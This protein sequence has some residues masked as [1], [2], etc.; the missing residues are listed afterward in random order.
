MRDFRLA[1]GL[2]HHLDFI[3]VEKWRCNRVQ[4][5]RAMH[6]QFLCRQT[7]TLV[8][9]ARVPSTAELAQN[10]ER[11]VLSILNAPA[12]AAPPTT[13][14][15]IKELASRS[16][17]RLLGIVA[18]TMALGRDGI[19]V[20]IRLFLRVRVRLS[21]AAS[22][23]GCLQVRLSCRAPVRTETLLPD[24]AGAERPAVLPGSSPF[25]SARLACSARC[26]SSSSS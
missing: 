4:E 5:G 13:R 11:V 6:R 10:L 7:Q 8:V 24:G 23:S 1:A 20:C 15:Y 3:V 17:V 2:V 26:R 9:L 22:A 16:V 18:Q 19:D 25:C 21:G 12:P 14:W